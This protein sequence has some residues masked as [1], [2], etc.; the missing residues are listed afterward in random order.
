MT[1]LTSVLHTKKRRTFGAWFKQVGWKHVV[2]WAVG[3][4]AIFPIVYIISTSLTNMGGI[5]NGTLFGQIDF[6]NYV[7]LVSDSEHPYLLWAWNTIFI[8]SVTAVLSVMMSALAA[9]AFSRLRF[10]E[11]VCCR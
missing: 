10:K 4:Y 2:A 6:S 5:E 11:W 9:Y 7:N 8:A 1:Q 3:V